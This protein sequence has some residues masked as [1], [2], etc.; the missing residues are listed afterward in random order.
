MRQRDENQFFNQRAFESMSRP[1]N[2]LGAIV[3]RNDLNTFWQAALDRC[4]LLFYRVDHFQGVHAIPSDDYTSD[5]FL[6]VLV[7]S[8]DAKGV[9]E[10]YVGDILDVNRN[11]ALR[12][13]H[14]VL[15][16]GCRLNQAHA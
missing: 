16:I 9:A 7:E 15:D 14:D 1:L 4:N 12:S 2:E 6:S 11:A 8:A 5:S 13:Q 10:L 3:K